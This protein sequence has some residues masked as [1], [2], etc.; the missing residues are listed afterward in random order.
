[1][2][3]ERER[4]MEVTSQS[5]WNAKTK[6]LYSISRTAVPLERAAISL[7]SG[8]SLI[9]LPSSSFAP[10]SPNPLALTFVWPRLDASQDLIARGM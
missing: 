5:S 2:R 4:K 9:N 1:M 10:S 7:I 6:A 3:E 8:I